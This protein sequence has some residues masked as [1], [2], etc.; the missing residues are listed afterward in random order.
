MTCTCHLLFEGHRPGGLADVLEALAKGGV[1]LDC[2][3]ARRR[4]ERPG[5]GVAYLT[6]IKGKKAMAAAEA[7]GVK[8]AGNIA[9][10]RVEGPNKAG[11]GAKMMRVIAE[12]GVNVR[13]VSGLA[14][15]NKFVAY[16]GL[17]S[18]EAADKA[19]KALK[20][21]DKPARAA[22]R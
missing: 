4:P 1:N 12:A 22:R 20:S 15:G 13:G 11:L 21:A 14:M 17:D 3:I 5:L 6:P 19:A 2:V 18:A 16:F 10:L 9:T 7:A 8:R